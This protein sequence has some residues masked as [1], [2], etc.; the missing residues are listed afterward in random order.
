MPPLQANR[1]H[2]SNPGG[3]FHPVI[4]VSSFPGVQDASFRLE[5]T[6]ILMK[7]KNAVGATY[8]VNIL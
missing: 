7:L 3:C 5:A 2:Y 8:A 4:C 1:G 6:G